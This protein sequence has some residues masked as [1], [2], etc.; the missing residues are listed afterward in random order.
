MMRNENVVRVG[1]SDIKIAQ[2]PQ[3]I[4]TLGLGSCIGVVVY[5]KKMQIAGLAHI[6]LPDSTLSKQQLLNPF[7][8]ADTAIPYLINALCEKGARKFALKAKV[9]GG[10]QMFKFEASTPMMRIGPRN[11]T[12]VLEELEKHRIPVVAKCVGGSSGRTIQFDPS[13]EELFIRTVYKGEKFI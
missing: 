5:D 9:A 7:K 2:A 6:M 10:A 1:I 4:R 12:A 11:V 13:T 3:S 8:F